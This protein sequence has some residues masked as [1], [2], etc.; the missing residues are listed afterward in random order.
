[1]ED[2]TSGICAHLRRIRGCR[3][4][5]AWVGS[6][7]RSG[8]PGA[9]DRLSRQPIGRYYCAFTAFSVMFQNMPEAAHATLTRACHIN[10]RTPQEE[11]LSLAG[12]ARRR[13]GPAGWPSPCRSRSAPPAGPGRSRRPRRARPDGACTVMPTCLTDPALGQLASCAVSRCLK[14]CV[15]AKPRQITNKAPD[16]AVSDPDY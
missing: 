6:R 9:P 12:G 1:M 2:L 5:A 11:D 4:Q 14:P 10:Q 15:M 7:A 8:Q 16:H 13:P 3:D